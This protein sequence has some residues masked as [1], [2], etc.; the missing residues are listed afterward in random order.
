MRN[1]ARFKSERL[2]EFLKCGVVMFVVFTL[3]RLIVVG[4]FA[5]R[6]GS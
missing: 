2:T 4:T 3:L 6:I 1:K 5:F